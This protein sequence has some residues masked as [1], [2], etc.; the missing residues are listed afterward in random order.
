MQ[1]AM[2]QSTAFIPMSMCSVASLSGMP[3]DRCVPCVHITVSVDFMQLCL[4]GDSEGLT[5]LQLNSWRQT[6]DSV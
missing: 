3:G 6:F 1:A 4:A 2:W 5:P